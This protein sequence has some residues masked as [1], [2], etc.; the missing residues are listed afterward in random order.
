MSTLN[1][2]LHPHHTSLVRRPITFQSLL[3]AF[4]DRVDPYHEIDGGP[5]HKQL[6][7]PRFNVTETQDAF[8]LDG[9]L[10]GV[11]EK[12]QITVE[13]F[14]N[15]VLIIRGVVKPADTETLEDP[16]KKG[17]KD[18]VAPNKSMYHA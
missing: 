11:T 2:I 4:E 10:P 18:E 1:C 14:Q 15:Q 12:K 7:R 6:G 9:E 8:I 3:H 5:S 13:W 16:F 17:L